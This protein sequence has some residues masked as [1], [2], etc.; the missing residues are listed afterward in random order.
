MT[1]SA[2][3]T[4]KICLLFA[5]FI[6]TIIS[7]FFLGLLTGDTIVE[8]APKISIAARSFRSENKVN[9]ITDKLGNKYSSYMQ[10]LLRN[11]LQAQEFNVSK[12]LSGH[13]SW[14]QLTLWSSDFHISPIADIKNL[15][16]PSF[17]F[18]IDSYRSMQV[19]VNVIDKS[20]SGHC[21]LTKTCQRCTILFLPQF[22][23]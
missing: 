14:G 17:N 9:F 13:E 4:S 20:L 10:Q 23:L 5:V 11:T 3:R 15:M 1:E 2:M 12:L 8:I 7:I 6:G 16:Q 19:N 21:H 22:N 18:L